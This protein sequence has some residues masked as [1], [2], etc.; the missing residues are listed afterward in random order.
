MPNNKC[1]RDWD[2]REDRGTRL[3]VKGNVSNDALAGDAHGAAEKI[4]W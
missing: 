3:K 4:G 2:I 1:K